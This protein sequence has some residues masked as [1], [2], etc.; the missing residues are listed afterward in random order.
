LETKSV[1]EM[2]RGAIAERAEYEMQKI[3]ENILDP[4]TAANKKRVLTLT[5]E[6]HPDAERQSLHMLCVAK[7]KLEP[8]HAV[9]TAL[10]VTTDESGAT[11]VIELTPQIPGQ[12]DLDGGEQE[13][14][15]R[16]RVIEGGQ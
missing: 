8:T 13:A 2:A 3:I 15:V 12:L 1:L 16:L 5:L 4:N 11:A 9:T 10:Y 7:S 14:P 6:I